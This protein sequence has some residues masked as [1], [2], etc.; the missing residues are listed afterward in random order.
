MMDSAAENDLMEQEE[1]CRKGL[2]TLTTALFMRFF[3]L[4][5]LV[6][7]LVHRQ[8]ELWILGLLLFVSLITLAGALP[9]VREWKLQRQ[10]L[11]DI[12]SQYE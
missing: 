11:R 1:T 12:L 5:L 8:M 10:K 9:L 2:K 3:V 6:F 4:I 7:I